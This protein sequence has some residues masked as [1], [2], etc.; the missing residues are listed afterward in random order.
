MP[1]TFTKQIGVYTDDC[2]ANVQGGVLN[3]TGDGELIMGEHPAL[4]GYI[5]HGGF[6]FLNV[7]IP[8]NAVI[9]SAKITF[10]NQSNSSGTPVSIVKGEAHDSAPA[11]STFANFMARTRCSATIPWSPG[12]QTAG[13]SVDTPDLKTI[14]QEIVDRANWESNNDMVLFVEN[15]GTLSWILVWDYYYSAAKS[16]VLEVIYTT[17]VGRSFGVVI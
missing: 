17:A 11:F 15:N 8:K 1:T 14:I 9:V 4:S 3:F 6:R 13:A 7:T 5:Y 2:F 16:A 10:V 12:A